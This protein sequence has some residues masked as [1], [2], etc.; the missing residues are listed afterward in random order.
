MFLLSQ[1]CHR[2]QTE[3]TQLQHPPAGV[4]PGGPCLPPPPKNKRGERERKGKERK[5]KGKEKE[6]HKETKSS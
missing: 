1:A 4:D 5:E 3:A 6:G 2:P